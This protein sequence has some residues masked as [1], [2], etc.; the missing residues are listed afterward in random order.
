MNIKV[1]IRFVALI[2]LTIIS[3]TACRKDDIC[4]GDGTP[5]LKIIFVDN[6]NPATE[7]P[8][9]ELHVTAL[10]QQDTLIKGQTNIKR[11]SIP[12]NVNDDISNFIFTS[13]QNAD[14]LIFHYTREQVFV[15]KSCGYKIIFHQLIVDLQQDND[16]WIKQIEL[17]NNDVVTDTVVHL[18]IYH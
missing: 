9:G 12:L 6:S 8:V 13:G 15:S 14:T 5:D 2:V 10:P 18:K 11:L 1:L 3:L 7:K 17:I 16:N 4:T